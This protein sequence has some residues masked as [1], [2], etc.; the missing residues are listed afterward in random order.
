MQKINKE[1]F[2]ILKAFDDN[3]FLSDIILIG[4]WFF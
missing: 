4:S 2:N 3:E 1:F